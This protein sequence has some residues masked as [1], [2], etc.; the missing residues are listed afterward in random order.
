MTGV[1]DDADYVALLKH[2]PACV[3]CTAGRPCQVND[4]LRAAAQESAVAIL[5]APP[6]GLAPV[7]GCK[8]LLIVD[9]SGVHEV[10][11]VEV[12]ACSWC[13]KS[14]D[15]LVVVGIFHS[16]S[17]PGWDICACSWCMRLHEL[18]PLHAH[19]EGS[20]CIPRHRDGA[21]AAIPAADP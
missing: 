5:T 7:P 19:P 15:G 12:D 20:W 6:P 2:G 16:D 3:V 10:V 13:R 17:G 18:L 1:R 11:R 14:S 21:P 4:E 9:E 8:T